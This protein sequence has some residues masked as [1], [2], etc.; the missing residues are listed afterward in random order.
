M[1]EEVKH[2]LG[3]F[4]QTTASI[5]A[6]KA[7]NTGLKSDIAAITKENQ[8]LKGALVQLS[9]RVSKLEDKGGAMSDLGK[10]VDALDAHVAPHRAMMRRHDTPA[11]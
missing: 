10:R 3:E 6:L 7:E 4:E 2:E 1:T 11:A 9:G 5:A 8:D